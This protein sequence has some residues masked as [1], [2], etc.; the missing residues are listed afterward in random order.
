MIEFIIFYWRENFKIV[1]FLRSNPCNS[2]RC[3]ISIPKDF[4]LSNDLEY[5]ILIKYYSLDITEISSFIRHYFSSMF[6]LL[7]AIFLVLIV[8]T[9]FNFNN[10]ILQRWKI[11]IRKSLILYFHTTLQSISVLTSLFQHRI[12]HWIKDFILIHRTFFFFFYIRYRKC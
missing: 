4:S 8:F 6:C 5:I 1:C 11:I 7:H 3:P 2:T 9:T 12:M 10:C